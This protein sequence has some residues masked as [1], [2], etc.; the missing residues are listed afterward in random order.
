MMLAQ[1]EN[2]L[3][4]TIGLAPAVIGRPVIERVVKGLLG[5]LREGGLLFVGPAEAGR[6]LEH[7]LAYTRWRRSFAFRKA[8]YG[9]SVL[10]RSHA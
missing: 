5:A 8:D 4:Q 3:Q 1:V 6:M 2:L 7:E 9:G 10:E